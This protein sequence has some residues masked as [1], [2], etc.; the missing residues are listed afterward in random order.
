MQ[1]LI[2]KELLSHPRREL[3]YTRCRVNAYALQYVQEVSVRVDAIQPARP[4]EALH[5]TGV[6]GTDFGPAE[7]P[8]AAIDWYYTQRAF[9]M[10]LVYVYG[11]VRREH[12]QCHPGISRIGQGM[13]DRVAG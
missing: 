11:G 8:N 2:S 4:D 3:G 7:Q 5:D 13:G 10:V 6:L 9:K 1:R 12:L